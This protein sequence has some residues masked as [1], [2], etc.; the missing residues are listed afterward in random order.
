M[1]INFIKIALRNFRKQAVYSLIK[2][3]GLSVS[4]A[5]CILMFLWVHHE[6]SFDRHLPD[7]ERM[8]RVGYYGVVRGNTVH[9]VQACPPMAPVLQSDFPEVE[10]VTRFRRL[11][12]PVIR[13]KDKVF[14]EERWFA[15]DA[16]FF[17]VFQ[18]PFLAGNPETAL[19]EPNSL[20]IT[21]TTARRYFGDENPLGK[22]LHAD[23]RRDWRVTGVVA[24]MPANSH[25]HFD[26]LAAMHTYR[27]MG[28]EA[29]WLSNNYYTYL[30]LREGV[31]WRR[32]ES[33]LKREELTYIKPQIAEMFGMSLEQMRGQGNEYFHFLQPVTW[34]H[35]NSHLE[36]ELEPNGDRLYV[37]IF[38]LA[39]LAILILA[40]ANF[41][42]LSTAR[43][44]GRAREVG[45]RK[46]LGSTR[47]VLIRQ[48]LTE[49]VAYA[50][51]AMILALWVVK[52]SLLPFRTF[53]GKHLV[54]SLGDPMVLFMLLAFTL[55]V[56]LSA[57]LYPAFYLSSFH[58]VNVLRKDPGSKRAWLRSALV[59]FQFSIAIVLL[60]G[61]FVVRGQVE[62][63]HGKKLNLEKERIVNIH[64]A[65]DLKRNIG[66]FKRAILEHP[67]VMAATNSDYL[68]GGLV[69]DSF[70]QQPQ[71]PD[72]ETRVIHHLFA[73]ADYGR[74]YGLEVVEGVFFPQDSG[75]DQRAL[76]LNESAVKILGLKEP[77]G[78]RLVRDRRG[79]PIPIVG[80]IRDFHFRSIHHAIDPLIINVIGRE[81]W[82]GRELS[83]RLKTNRIQETIAFLERTWK[84][85]SENQAFEYAFFDEHY[86]DLYRAELRTH[87]IF[88]AFSIFALFIAGLGLLGLS[89]FMAEQRTKE[90]GVRKVLG[91]TSTGIVILLFRQF[92]RWIFFATVIAWPLGFFLMH[93]WL[94]S[95]AY[96]VPLG[97]GAFLPS[98]LF[99]V[100]VVLL[101]VGFQTIKAARANPADS[102][103]YE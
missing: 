38:I 26:F 25:F 84:R 23:Q 45:I 52:V 97:I 18:L 11:G 30:I 90:I 73:D 59:I 58:P 20:V 70:Y 64:K 55:I 101:S 100:L 98:F 88:A 81:A 71:Q 83:V 63:I 10:A 33:K 49:S 21:R 103:R 61:T 77:V 76:V 35:L 12:N 86:D 67:N 48:F 54:L 2:I 7:V 62:F 75:G 85:F 22:T 92:G 51:G 28:T 13:Y 34:V 82:G 65:D 102:L 32:F 57:G 5:C 37:I 69:G 99:A 40:V 96:H 72:S 95:F 29:T 44:M 41:V 94:R 68:L 36:H 50:C 27:N 15:A 79:A 66:P 39:G 1:W 53:T 78:K 8:Y 89:A 93:N 14:S 74:V 47:L 60:V 80:V 16:D 91:A 19:K 17:Q 46:T 87:S 43:S 3:V 9:G 42:N 4:I 31:D 56:G 24:D 6:L